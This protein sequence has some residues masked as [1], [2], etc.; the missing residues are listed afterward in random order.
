MPCGGGL[1]AAYIC[2]EADGGEDHDNGGFEWDD[3]SVSTATFVLRMVVLVLLGLLGLKIVFTLLF[4]CTRKLR[5]A[6]H[7][8][9][10]AEENPEND[11]GDSRTS[12]ELGPPP[13]SVDAPPAYQALELKPV[14]EAPTAAADTVPLLSAQ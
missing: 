4:I 7:P 13:L 14:D 10:L 12:S 5:R 9:A 11:D 8:V 3:D 1:C 6:S 2:A